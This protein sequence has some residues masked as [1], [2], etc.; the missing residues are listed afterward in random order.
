MSPREEISTPTEPFSEEK[1]NRSERI[2]DGVVQ[3]ASRKAHLSF[4]KTS[5]TKNSPVSAII[6]DEG[7]FCIDLSQGL[8]PF[9]YSSV[10]DI[11]YMVPNGLGQPEFFLEWGDT[12]NKK[13]LYAEPSQ[14]GVQGIP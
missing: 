3:R 5:A 9:I 13:N 6:S 7:S 14:T 12:K 11:R 1:R 4:S 2:L 10:F 8:P